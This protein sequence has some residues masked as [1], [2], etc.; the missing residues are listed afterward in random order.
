LTHIFPF[1]QQH[2]LYEQSL[3]IHHQLAIDQWLYDQL[4]SYPHQFALKLLLA[5]GTFTNFLAPE[6]YTIL[7]PTSVASGSQIRRRHDPLQIYSPK[8]EY[9][10]F[11][12]TLSQFIDNPMQSGIYFV[13][14]TTYA[15]LSIFV[16]VS[17][18]HTRFV[19]SGY[20]ASTLSYISCFH[21][22]DTKAQK[23]ANDLLAFALPRSA[24]TP[25]LVK[26]LRSQTAASTNVI[27][28]YLEV[29]LDPQSRGL[30]CQVMSSFTQEC[31]KMDDPKGLAL[32]IAYE[33]LK[34]EKDLPLDAYIVWMPISNE[35]DP[36]EGN[37]EDYSVV[38]R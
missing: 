21:R 15:M 11:Y 22:S 6:I 8:E 26:V 25:E 9:S 33:K 37:E 12:R 34:A 3:W 29:R 32:L 14:G 28:H 30:R 7:G 13:R 4:Q 23:I 20:C 35:L 1:S 18:M 36:S 24:K 19:I 16:T 5:A 10:S 38:F 2:P 31:Q 27:D 17:F